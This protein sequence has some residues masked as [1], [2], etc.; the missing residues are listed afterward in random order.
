MNEPS[1]SAKSVGGFISN[2]WPGNLD[3]NELTPLYANIFNEYSKIDSGSIMAFEPIP[4]P[5]DALFNV[6]F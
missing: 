6:G 5:P 2:L 4:L 1:A 3:K